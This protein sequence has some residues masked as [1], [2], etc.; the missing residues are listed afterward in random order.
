MPSRAEP[1]RLRDYALGTLAGLT[2]AVIWGGGAVVSRHLVGSGLAPVDLAVL[3]YLGCFL[4]AAAILIARPELRRD[5][6]PVG[7]LAMLL[8][9]AGPPYQLLLLAGYGHATA[10]GGSL[11]VSGLLPVFALLLAGFAGQPVPAL[12]RL[13]A[14]LALAGLTVFALGSPLNPSAT[15][16][17]VL[18]FAAAASLWAALNHLVAR[19]QIDP[20]QLTLA[21]AGWSPV[22]LPLWWLAPASHLQPSLPDALLQIA[23]HGILVAFL[24]TWAFFLAVRRLGAGAAGV[25]QAATPLCAAALGALLLGETLVEAQLAGTAMTVA[26]I[27]LAVSGGWFVRRSESP[28]RDDG[29][30]RLART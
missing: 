6:L 14:G 15:S 28:A 11:L 18:V 20:L 17:G 9:L 3:R 22:F 30:C 2:A 24:A 4:V 27:G 19:W 12:S 7:R 8:L 5:R 21:L 25:L 10:G 13:G 1:H 26:G 29:R 23:Y 16:L